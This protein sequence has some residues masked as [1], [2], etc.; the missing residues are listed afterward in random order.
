ML[1]KWAAGLAAVLGLLAVSPGNF[2]HAATDTSHR[3]AIQKCIKANR[4]ARSAAVAQLHKDL[5][6]ASDLSGQARQ[7]AAKAALAKFQQAAES[8]R[9]AFTSCAQA[10]GGSTGG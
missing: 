2:A 5:A 7:D 6:A 8:A 10:A 3:A 9:T 1:W 4:A